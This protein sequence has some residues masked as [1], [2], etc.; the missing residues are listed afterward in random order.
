MERMI[1]DRTLFHKFH[2][3]NTSNM[4]LCH[5]D[6]SRVGFTESKVCVRLVNCCHRLVHRT[7]VLPVKCS[8]VFIFTKSISLLH[9][10]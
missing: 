1:Q 5:V 10:L 2:D 6:V 8:N 9:F 7:L 4:N 3:N